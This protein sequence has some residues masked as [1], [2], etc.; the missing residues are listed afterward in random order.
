MSTEANNPTK[1]SDTAER[2][3]TE[4]AQPSTT[5]VQFGGETPEAVTKDDA[6]ASWEDGETGDAEEAGAEG[7]PEAGDAGGKQEEEGGE[8]EAVNDL[9]DF[10][11]D[12]EEV[13]SKYEE[14][15]FK[16]GELNQA[17]LSQE[18]WKS[19]EAAGGDVTKS[20]LPEGTYKYLESALGIPKAMAKELEAGLVAKHQAEQAGFLAKTV[21]GGVEAYNKA[22]QWAQKGGYSEEQ[23]QRFRE[24]FA[25]GGADREDAVEALM[26]RFGRASGGRD[27]GRRG[28][29]RGRRSTPERDV[30]GGAG[31]G[32][33]A[34]GDRFKSRAE[35]TETW[36][37]AYKAHSEARASGDQKTI[38]ET[39]KVLDAIK[40]K[41]RRGY[42]TR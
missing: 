30:T 2:V 8:G 20:G 22:I 7:D 39:R 24:A 32:Q 5:S 28:P 26:S 33:G 10:D 16:D 1:T 29:P 13:V 27:G 9:P 40:A 37:T 38:K 25:K 41:A 6:G 18:Y 35:H 4:I 12:S 15:Y 14:R 42:A 3:T 17:V 23:R 11:P 31:A 36:N 34:S 21:P 19:F